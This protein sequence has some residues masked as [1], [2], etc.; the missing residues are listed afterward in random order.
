MRV[1]SRI[2]TKQSLS[3]FFAG[4][5]I[6]YFFSVMFLFLTF[7]FIVII[8]QIVHLAGGGGFPFGLSGSLECTLLA[9]HFHSCVNMVDAYECRQDHDKEEG[10]EKNF[11][12]TFR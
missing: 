7:Y 9:G 2:E 4:F 11:T 1:R 5:I 8:I 6:Y 12:E 10:E 3:A